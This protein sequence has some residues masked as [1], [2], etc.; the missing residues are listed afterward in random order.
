VIGETKLMVD[1]N[2]TFNEIKID[3]DYMW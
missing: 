2:E 3:T 1:V